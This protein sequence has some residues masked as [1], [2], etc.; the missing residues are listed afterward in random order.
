[1]GNYLEMAD[2]QRERVLALLELGWSYRRIQRETGVRRETV[3]SYDPR[4]EPKPAKV[5]TGSQSVCEPYRLHHRGSS[6]QRAECP[7]HLAGPQGRLPLQPW[8]LLSQALHPENKAPSPSPWPPSMQVTPPS[9][10]PPLTSS[11]TWLR[12]KPPAP[13][14]TWW[15]TFARWICSCWRTWG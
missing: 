9:I 4:R 3:A 8:L 15:I 10:A 5:P 2:K 7:A 6:R 1:M 12:L 14:R 13:A 11:K